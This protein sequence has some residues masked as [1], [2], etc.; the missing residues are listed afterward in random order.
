MGGTWVADVFRAVGG[1]LINQI[2]F[3]ECLKKTSN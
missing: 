1:L 2:S 3:S